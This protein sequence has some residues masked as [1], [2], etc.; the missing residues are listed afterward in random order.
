M[1]LGLS[2]YLSRRQAFW[3]A[4]LGLLLFITMVGFPASAIRA[5]IMGF[6]VLFAQYIGRLNRSGNAILLAAAIMLLV[7]PKLLR[8]DIGFQLSFAA[9]CGLIYLA[10]LI[11]KYFQKIPNFLSLRDSMVMTLAA[12]IMTLPLI[13]YHFDQLSVLAPLVNV[14]VLPIVPL[15]MMSGLASLLTGLIWLPIAR[16]AIWLPWL[17]LSYLIKVVELFAEIPFVAFEM[18]NFPWWLIPVSYLLIGLVLIK[19]RGRNTVG[20]PA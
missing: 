16:V 13:I 9:A 4:V 6:L 1:N 10:P 8:D 14:L 17:I 5:G 20:T 3:F 7:N 2:L 18:N 19:K 12:Q 11:E 15:I